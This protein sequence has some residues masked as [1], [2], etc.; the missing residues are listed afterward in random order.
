ML[1]GVALTPGDNTRE[2]EIDKYIARH[3]E[4]Q[5]AE[6]SFIQTHGRTPT[7]KELWAISPP[8]D[9]KER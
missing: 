6:W 8:H 7:H 3:T 9:R 1:I 2:R 4:L 5:E